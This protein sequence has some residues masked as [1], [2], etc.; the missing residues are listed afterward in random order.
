[1]VTFQAITTPLDQPVVYCGHRPTAPPTMHTN[2]LRGNQSGAMRWVGRQL[3][4]MHWTK[5]RT[6]CASFIVGSAPRL[7]DRLLIDEYKRQ[8]STA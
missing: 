2:V 7:E 5:A 4:C 6:T 3:E 8:V 1:M